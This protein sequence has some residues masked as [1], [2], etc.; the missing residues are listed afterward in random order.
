MGIRNGLNRLFGESDHDSH[1]DSHSLGSNNTP[2]QQPSDSF[3]TPNT[4]AKSML[5]PYPAKLSYNNSSNNV[6]SLI[7][8]F[9]VCLNRYSS[10]PDLGNV[11]V[12]CTFAVNYNRVPAESESKHIENIC[13]HFNDVYPELSIIGSRADENSFQF[14][15]SGLMNLIG[16]MAANKPL[17]TK[18]DPVRFNHINNLYS[19][20]EPLEPLYE[21][22]STLLAQVEKQIA[23]FC[24]D[25]SNF[26]RENRKQ[27]KATRTLEELA[28]KSVLITLDNILEDNQ[29]AAAI[30]DHFS[31]N[32]LVCNVTDETQAHRGKVTLLLKF[33]NL[34]PDS[35]PVQVATN[36]IPDDIVKQQLVAPTNTTKALTSPA[37]SSTYPNSYTMKQHIPSETIMPPNT[38]VIPSKV[39][40]NGKA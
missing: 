22:H 36:A 2:I 29:A 8:C 37:S 25:P 1:D 13:K 6:D 40:L 9:L 27:F 4:E 23:D 17:L 26:T 28:G 32:N 11:D 20:S 35:Q 14:H 31:I 21:K 3:N 16:L 38:P 33:S 30:D 5:T 10:V 7:K 18:I 34:I 12:D 39:S 24:K 19:T 15:V